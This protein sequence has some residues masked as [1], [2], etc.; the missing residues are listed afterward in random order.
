VM[1]LDEYKT[2][3]SEVLD[4]L[5]L[6]LCTGQDVFKPGAWSEADWLALLRLNTLYTIACDLDFDTSEPY[7]DHW[8]SLPVR[9]ELK[10]AVLNNV[11]AI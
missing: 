8:W 1:H 5:P 9:D 7:L 2:T 11:R 10:R 4:G 3:C 6:E